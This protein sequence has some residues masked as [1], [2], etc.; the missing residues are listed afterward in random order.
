[1]AA[2]GRCGDSIAFVAIDEV[3]SDDRDSNLVLSLQV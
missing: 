2:D 1:M 3:A